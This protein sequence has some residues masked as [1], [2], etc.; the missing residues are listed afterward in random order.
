M[1]RVE[2]IAVAAFPLVAVS[3]ILLWCGLQAEAMCLL[4]GGGI[5]NWWVLIWAIYQAEK[6]YYG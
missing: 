5:I 3:L 2:K 1:D 4:V 6:Q